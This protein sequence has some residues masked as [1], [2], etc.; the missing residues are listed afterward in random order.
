MTSEAGDYIGQ[1]QT[2]FYGATDGTFAASKNFDNGVSVSFDNAS[3]N[4]SLDF[5]APQSVLLAPG[6]YLGAT[7][8]P[9]QSP[10]EPGLDVSGDGRGCN[11]LTGSFVIRLVSYG[12]GTTINAFW[13]TFEQHCEGVVPALRGEIRY[14]VPPR[15]SSTPSLPVGSSTP[16]TQRDPWA[17]PTSFPAPGG[18]LFSQECAASLPTPRPSR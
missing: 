6:T 10:T 2:Y 16:A 18:H 11:T 4:W 15:S 9:F 5:A 12:S 7:R 8:F 14:N 13:A 17:G 3:H 1:G